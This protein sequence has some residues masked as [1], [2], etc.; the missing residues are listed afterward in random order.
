[1]KNPRRI[2]TAA[3]YVAAGALGAT[4]LT[5]VA[6][7]AGGGSTAAD[8]G[9][10]HAVPAA[11][12]T[13]STPAPEDGYGFGRGGMRGGGHGPGDGDPGEMADRMGRGGLSGHDADDWGPG[14]RADRL[15]GDRTGG[16]TGGGWSRGAGG[17]MLHG[18]LT[19]QDT[20]GTAVHRVQN[21]TVTAISATSITVASTDGYDSTYAITDTTVLRRDFST[22]KAADIK[23]KDNVHISGTVSGTSVTALRVRAVS[24]DQQAKIQQ[25]L[26]DWRSAHPT[27]S[28]SATTSGTSY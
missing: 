27:P 11:T 20:T 8:S 25:R 26:D 2:A 4:A 19:V 1:M 7:A 18:D 23:V 3:A 10:W 21:G 15:G 22:V 13:P 6:M 9:A 12:S 17:D 5:G 14:D 24:A 16:G 28:S